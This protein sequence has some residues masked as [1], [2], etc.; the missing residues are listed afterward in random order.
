MRAA[1][2]VAILSAGAALLAGCGG[3]S[4]PSYCSAVASLKSSIQAVP[5][6]G[7]LSNGTNAL[8]SALTQVENDAKAV[9]S[10]AKSDFPNETAALQSSVNALSSSAKQLGSSPTPSAI[11]QTASNA[12][13]VATASKNLQSATSSKCG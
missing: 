8:K 10:S 13:A 9:V 11:A 12:A 5:T 2:W 6:T 4:K 1:R 7:V 3:S